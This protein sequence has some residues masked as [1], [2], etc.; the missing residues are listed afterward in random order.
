METK[1]A[2]KECA[3]CP[4]CRFTRNSKKENFIYK[5]IRRVQSSCPV[6]GEANKISG[7]DI[8]KSNSF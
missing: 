7:K 4:L 1:D 3:G 8:Q 2:V 6:C 5:M